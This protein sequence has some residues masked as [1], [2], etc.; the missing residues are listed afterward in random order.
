[1]AEVDLSTF[2]NGK[3]KFYQFK[4][5]FRF[6]TDTFLLA[7]FV[8][9]KG[10]EKVVDLGTGCGVIPL[11][12]LLKYPR[13]KAVGVDV[14]RENV[15]LAV[16]N[17]SLNGVL[18]RFQGVCLNVKD[19]KTAFK[20]SSFDV[21]ISNPPFIELGRGSISSG[22]LKAVA[23]QE[24][25]GKLE[26]FIRAAS[27]LLKNK[28]KF[29]LLLPNQRFVDAIALCRSLNLEPKR[30]RFI[31]PE[32]GKEANLFLLEAVKGGGKGIVVEPPLVIYE[33][34]VK[35]IYTNEVDRKY[36]N[37]LPCM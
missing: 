37:F 22:S 4:K 36:K 13:L 21:V 20:A 8:K 33:D 1:M 9:V 10:R 26:D 6:G 24:I 28:G 19:V 11:L 31:Y 23:R 29:Y 18:D 7:D 3:C 14:L 12:L 17:A 16:K 25:K 5:G 35:R 27:Y 15:E 34:A 2:L 30:L 32:K